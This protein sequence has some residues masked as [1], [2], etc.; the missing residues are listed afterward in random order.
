MTTTTAASGE[1]R[2]VT[3]YRR[4]SRPDALPSDSEQRSGRLRDLASRHLRLPEPPIH[5]C[6]R[7]LLELPSVA[8]GVE[9]DLDLE[10]V[11]LGG[12]ALEAQALQQL[13]AVA[14]E[15]GSPVA[16]LGP[17]HQARELIRA[18]TQPEAAHRPVLDAP[19]LDVARPDDD[20]GHF[21]AGEQA[22]HLRGL[23]RSIRVH[24]DD[25]RVVAR[26]R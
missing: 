21:G 4:A 24:H 20:V 5:E 8:Q 9:E 23:V 13:A 17:G 3:A 7:H 26:E 18:P 14:L 22:A 6:D 19:S 16:H 25:A 2:R 15:P 10:G 12:D 11:T 1:R